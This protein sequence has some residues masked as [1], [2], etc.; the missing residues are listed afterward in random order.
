MPTRPPQKSCSNWLLTLVCG[1]FYPTN[2][3][4]IQKSIRETGGK[5]YE[6]EVRL[7]DRVFSESIAFAEPFEVWRI[8]AR[9]ITKR[10]QAEA[11]LRES[12]ASFRS[13]FEN[14]A[15]GVVIHEMLYGGDGRAVDYRILSANPAFEKHTGL[16]VAAIQGK[17]GKQAYG[18]RRGALPGNIFQGGP[19]RGAGF[20]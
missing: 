7:K 8:Y 1:I 15:E 4:E 11:T 20:F 17:T 10:V 19:D 6:C 2:W 3:Q 12:E 13:L 9:D 5:N 16:S 18:D 14:M